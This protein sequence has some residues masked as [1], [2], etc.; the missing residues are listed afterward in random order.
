[1]E[2]NDDPGV[3]NKRFAPRWLSIASYSALPRRIIVNYVVPTNLLPRTTHAKQ[4]TATMISRKAPPPEAAAIN[5]N[6]RFPRFPMFPRFPDKN[7]KKK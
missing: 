4:I 3:F 1:M 7:K 5:V 2:E 6:R